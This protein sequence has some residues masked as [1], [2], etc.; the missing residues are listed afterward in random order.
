MMVLSGMGSIGG[1]LLGIK[2][3]IAGPSLSE[4]WE[5]SADQDWKESKHLHRGWICFNSANDTHGAMRATSTSIL[6][7]LNTKDLDN[8]TVANSPR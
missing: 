4:K 8:P 7:C 1:P 6:F 2:T 3:C 5:D